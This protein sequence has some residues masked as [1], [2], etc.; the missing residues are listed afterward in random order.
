M[1]ASVADSPGESSAFAMGEPDEREQLQEGGL[2]LAPSRTHADRYACALQ[3][4][5]AGNDPVY[6]GAERARAY[7]HSAPVGRGFREL[8]RSVA[9]GPATS[10]QLAGVQAI[11]DARWTTSSAGI[12]SGANA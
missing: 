10:R 1:T 3:A 4:A 7:G 11:Q 2:L 5:S 9:P 12:E 8:D 6:D